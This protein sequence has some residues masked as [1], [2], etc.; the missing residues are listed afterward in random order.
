[1]LVVCPMIGP[2]VAEGRDSVR[3][4]C[5]LSVGQNCAR[6]CAASAAEMRTCASAAARVWLDT[7]TCAM[8]PSSEA[9]PK[10]AHHLPRSAASR[11]AAA[12]QLP[13][14]LYAA[15]MSISGRL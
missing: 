9:S 5:E 13:A 8:S 15:G 10:I 7:S 11:G 1:L 6:D 2:V 3:V 14:S 12:C 4:T